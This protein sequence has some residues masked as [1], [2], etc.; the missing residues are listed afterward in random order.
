MV[1]DSITFPENLTSFADTV[2]SGTKVSIT[3]SLIANCIG[4]LPMVSVL[5]PVGASQLSQAMLNI[6]TVGTGSPW[7]SNGN[8]MFG[9]AF[10]CVFN[11]KIVEDSAGFD[12]DVH[13]EKEINGEGTFFLRLGLTYK[14]DI[15]FYN[16]QAELCWAD[17]LATMVSWRDQKCYTV[18]E[19]INQAGVVSSTTMMGAFT[20]KTTLNNQILVPAYDCYGLKFLPFFNATDPGGF[21]IFLLNGPYLLFGVNPVL[22]LRILLW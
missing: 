22:L 20:A 19:V 15:C 4:S 3:F 21:N 14:K 13:T 5:S 8:L 16:D 12:Q 2:G 1:V 9:E 18:P 7:S 11:M 10:H 6:Y 17:A